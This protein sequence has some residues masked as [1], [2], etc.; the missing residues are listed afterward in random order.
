M[1]PYVKACIAVI[2]VFM[3]LD[4]IWLSQI[5]VDFYK[6][7]IGQHLAAEPNFAAAAVFYLLYLTGLMYFAVASAIIRGTMMSATFSGGLFGL[8]AYGTYDL[9]NLATMANWP[10]S[11]T[12]ADMAWGTFLSAVASAAGYWLAMYPPRERRQAR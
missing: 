4:F 10:L 5:S 1:N 2:L 12:V 11:V 3:G 7:T 9:T 6:Q 8:I